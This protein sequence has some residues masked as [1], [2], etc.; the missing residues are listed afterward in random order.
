MSKS[1]ITGDGSISH[2]LLSLFKRGK[3]RQ[4]SKDRVDFQAQVR[5]NHK[6]SGIPREITRNDKDRNW[7]KKRQF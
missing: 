7:D 5:R 1:S 4:A 6:E 3:V 2:V